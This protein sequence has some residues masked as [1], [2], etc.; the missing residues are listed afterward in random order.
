MRDSFFRMFDFDTANHDYIDGGIV[1]D[2]V[3][4]TKNIKFNSGEIHE[5]DE[6]EQVVYVFETGSL[7]FENHCAANDKES[8][9]RL[10]DDSF[11]AT[12]EEILP[13]LTWDK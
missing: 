12:K 3:V 2:F 1:Y 7:H 11:V 8:V 6:F 4:I 5:G 13:Y 9:L 10:T